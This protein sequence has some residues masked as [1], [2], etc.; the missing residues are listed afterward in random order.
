MVA[1]TLT[2]TATRLNAAAVTL[3]VISTKTAI[4]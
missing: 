4:R 2:T 1:V 3:A